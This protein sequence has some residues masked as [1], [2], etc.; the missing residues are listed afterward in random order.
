MLAGWGLHDLRN[1]ATDG[2]EDAQDRLV[3]NGSPRCHPAQSD[4]G[5]SLDVAHDGA[6]DRTG[7]CDDE[8][9]GDVDERGEAAR[10]FR[11]VFESV[12]LV[13]NMSNPGWN[14]AVGKGGE[15]TGRGGSIP[16]TRVQ[17]RI[18]WY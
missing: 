11:A 5:A 12:T 14:K 10:L 1:D 9:L 2:S 7:L 4:D 15:E 17:N 6:G 8:E 18:E 13:Q 16:G 3:A